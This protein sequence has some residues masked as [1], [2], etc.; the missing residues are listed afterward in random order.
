MSMRDAFIV[1]EPPNTCIA[2]QQPCS[3]VARVLGLASPF[4]R[5]CL[6]HSIHKSPVSSASASPIYLVCPSICICISHEVCITCLIL[7]RLLAGL[8][9]ESR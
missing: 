4:I 5:W 9:I 6:W 2:I 7:P 8:A 1:G 3:R